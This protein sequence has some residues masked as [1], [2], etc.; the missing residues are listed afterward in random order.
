MGLALAEFFDVLVQNQY[1]NSVLGLGGVAVEAVRALVVVRDD[2]RR[3]ALLRLEL[4]EQRAARGLEALRQ[5]LARCS[6]RILVFT[7]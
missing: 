6:V 2:A 5:R 1:S 7:I 3:E 4:R